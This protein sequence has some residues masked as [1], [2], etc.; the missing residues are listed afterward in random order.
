[1][2]CNKRADLRTDGFSEYYYLKGYFESLGFPRINDSAFGPCGV[3][4]LN[5]G[6]S[7]ERTFYPL[8]HA[9]WPAGR[10]DI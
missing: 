7:K 6:C 10:P 1:M 9:H 3:I 4:G 2:R 5:G 8:F